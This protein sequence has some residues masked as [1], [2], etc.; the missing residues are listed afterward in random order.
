[1]N[2]LINSMDQITTELQDI[3]SFLEIT[4]SEDANEAVVRGNDLA[5]Y[6]ARTGKLV[7]DAKNHRDIKLRSEMIL[8]YKKLLEFPASVAVKYTDTLVENETYLLT[9]A[10]RLNAS[11]THQLDWCRTII[12]KAKA[13]MSSFNY[14]NQN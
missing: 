3:Q 9:W 6:M 1:M 7:A 8:D 11:C 12:S 10:T 2:S 5:V 4:M 14:G 13:E